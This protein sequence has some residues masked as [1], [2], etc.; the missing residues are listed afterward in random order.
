MSASEPT[1][2]QGGTV[3]DLARLGEGA[4]YCGMASFFQADIQADIQAEIYKKA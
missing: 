1:E 4:T 3:C 2:P